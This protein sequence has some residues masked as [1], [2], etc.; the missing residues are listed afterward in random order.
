MHVVIIMH[1]A[2]SKWFIVLM[3][4]SFVQ[5]CRLQKANIAS[6]AVDKDTI[7]ELRTRSPSPYLANASMSSVGVPRNFSRGEYIDVRP[8]YIGDDW[9]TD[10]NIITYRIEK[11]YEHDEAKFGNVDEQNSE[12]LPDLMSES[13][14]KWLFWSEY[15]GRKKSSRSLNLFIAIVVI[16]IQ[17]FAYIMLTYYVIKDHNIAVDQRRQ[18]CHGPNCNII[19]RNCMHIATGSVTMLLLI[20]FLWADIIDAVT[21]L[22]R[23]IC[24]KTEYYESDDHHNKWVCTPTQRKICEILGALLILIE[25]C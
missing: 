2:S 7:S 22:Y 12:R 18:N 21:V 13:T 19:E 24:K 15:K 10:P 5:V 20:G 16:L 4:N 3:F 25:L 6:L 17:L 23:H 11:I 14:N 1:M 8:V 9:G